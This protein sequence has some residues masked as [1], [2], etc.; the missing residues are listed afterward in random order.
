MHPADLV[1]G[2]IA[3]AFLIEFAALVGV[4]LWVIR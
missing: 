4:A 3:L 1:A 2:A